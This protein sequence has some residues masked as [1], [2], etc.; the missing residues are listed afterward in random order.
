[1]T[2]TLEPIHIV[3]GGLAGCEAAW[4][5]AK[6]GVP[7][8]LHEMRPVRTTDAHHT[9]TLAELVCSNSFR[10]DDSD[11]NAVGLLHHEMRG[12]D[13]LILQTGDTHK[14]PAGSALAVDRDGFAEAVQSAIENQ[15]LITIERGEVDGL[16]PED[17]SS[18]IIATGPL[19]SQDLSGAISS[20]T[21]EDSL[22]FFD[23][24]APIV[25][26]D[27]IDFDKAWFQSRYDK[28]EGSDYI[29]CP[30][31]EAQYNTFL[32]ALIKGEKTEFKEWEKGTPYF[33]GCLPI[34]VMAERGRETLRFGPMKPVGLTNPH[35]PQTKAWAI[36]QLRQDN[37][38]GTLYNLVGFQTKLKYGAQKGVFQS[39]PGLENAEFVRLGG[40]HRN[41][42]LNS[43]RLLDESFRLKA[44]PRLRFAGQI[45]GCEGYIESAAVGLMVGRFAAAERHDLV[46]APPPPTTSM[47]A[48]YNHITG[49]AREETYQ[50]MN[51]NFGLFP[52][53]EGEEGKRENGRKLKGRDRK[54][55]YSARGKRDF[56]N[57][58][59]STSQAAQ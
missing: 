9:D 22:A 46:F 32:D 26:K 18:V 57:W 45:T 50:P 16:P 27:S 17:W 11:F 43:P 15:P 29:N 19:T 47:G 33:E 41:T 31:D 21:G 7:V 52:D 4:Q 24:I 13:S 8:I 36:V 14:V 55:A 40:I 58:L 1:M 2:N 23:A 34:E 28:G 20:L 54:G 53:L 49:G 56:I 25:T 51:V 38:L 39:I 30:M 44:M 12:L 48:L 42:F 37:A 59:E 10:S 6:A 35:D 5:I 3:G